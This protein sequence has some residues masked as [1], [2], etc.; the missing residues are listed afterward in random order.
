MTV[1][2]RIVPSP[3]DPMAVA[4]V[5]RR[6]EL[7]GHRRHDPAPPPPQRLLSLRRRPLARRRRAPR[8]LRVVAVA[9]GRAI[10]EGRQEASRRARSVRAEQVQDRERPRGAEGDRPRRRG[11]QPPVWL[12]GIETTPIIA[13][14][15]VPL[16]NGI[17]HFATRELRP[18]T[19]ELFEQH[20]LPFAYDPARRRRALAPLPGRALGRRRGVEADARRVV[21]LRPLGRHRRSRRCSCSSGRSGRAR[22]RSPAS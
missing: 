22:E 7:H 21:R 12:D 11:V 1:P 6:R 8:L 20:V 18:H 10:R 16:A 19:P 5:V 14:E 2:E 17:L 4:R 13:G 9:R 15:I 3:T